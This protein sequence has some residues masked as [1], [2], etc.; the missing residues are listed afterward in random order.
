MLRVEVRS[1]GEATAQRDGWVRVAVVRPDGR[2]EVVSH[3]YGGSFAPKRD[4]VLAALAAV[5][6]KLI[7]DP[8]LVE[9]V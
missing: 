4:V 7:H 1:R 3:P 9:G 2:V 8:E 5:R 6:L